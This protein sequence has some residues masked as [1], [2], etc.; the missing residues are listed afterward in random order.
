MSS[1][2]D[3]SRDREFIRYALDIE[4]TETTAELLEDLEERTGF[5]YSDVAKW[6]Q[7]SKGTISQWAADNKYPRRIKSVCKA[8][9][10][11]RRFFDRP[12]F[13]FEE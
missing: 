13:G 11:E 9:I 10:H 2:R 4:V 6:M 7:C 12:R 1:K 5:R 8:I 3:K